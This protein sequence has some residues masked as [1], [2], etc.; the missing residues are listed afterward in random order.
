MPENNINF[1][2]QFILNLF[3]DDLK[4]TV[5]KVKLASFTHDAM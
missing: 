4:N 3:E 5:S 2:S 1:I